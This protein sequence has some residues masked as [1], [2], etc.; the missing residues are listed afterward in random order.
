MIKYIEGGDI[1]KSEMQSLIVPVNCVGVM[2]NGLAL[3]FKLRY[4]DV[5]SGY[6]AACRTKRIIKD[7]FHVYPIPSE[8]DKQLICFPTKNHYME[9]SD[10]FFIE[11]NLIKLRM[12]IHTSGISSLAFPAIGAG[13]GRLPWDLV[14]SVIDRV[15]KDVQIPVEV[16]EQWK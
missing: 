15:F 4:P 14:R 13:K 10:I 6:K 7:G 11:D 3:A 8:D 2:G 1:F 5:E 9:D 16:Y 12:G